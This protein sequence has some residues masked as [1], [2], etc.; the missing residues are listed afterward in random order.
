MKP[1]PSCRGT[2]FSIDAV[3]PHKWDVLC[4]TCLTHGPVKASRADAIAA[5][6]ALPRREDAEAM[7]LMVVEAKVLI[8]HGYREWHKR[9]DAVLNKEGG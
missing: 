1:C 7:R 4:A 6:D 9:A 2:E 8:P 5:W 3:A